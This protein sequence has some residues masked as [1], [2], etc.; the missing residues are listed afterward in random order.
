MITVCNSGRLPEWSNGTDSKSVVGAISPGVR[1]PHLPPKNFSFKNHKYL[2]KKLHSLYSL[3]MNTQHEIQSY[4][5]SQAEPKRSEMLTLHK[6]ILATYPTTDLW[7]YK[8]H[9]GKNNTNWIIGYGRYT[10]TYATGREVEWFPL[11]LSANKTGISVYILGVTKEGKYVAETYGK[12]LGKASV[13]KS[14]IR[15]KTLEH[16][17]LEALQ[18]AMKDGIDAMRKSGQLVQ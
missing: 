16:M 18:E 3:P 6:L 5:D 2:N 4:I 13:G 17:N 1:I 14:C 15:F 11:G 7:L 9:A 10:T 12:K 8:G